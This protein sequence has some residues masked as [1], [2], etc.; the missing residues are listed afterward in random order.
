MRIQEPVSSGSL[1]ILSKSL[2]KDILLKIG[3]IVEGVVLEVYPQGGMTLKI[4]ESTLPVRSA[5]TFSKGEVLRLKVL[6]QRDKPGELVLKWVGTKEKDTGEEVTRLP[7]GLAEGGG[8]TKAND[9]ENT[10]KGMSRLVSSLSSPPSTSKDLEKLLET[11]LKVFY[12]INPKI[13]EKQR[14]NLLKILLNPLSEGLAGLT[15]KIQNILQEVPKGWIRGALSDSIQGM[16]QPM[17]MEGLNGAHLQEALENSGVLLETKIKAFAQETAADPETSARLRNKIINDSKYILLKL[18]A[19]I[20]EKMQTEVIKG[21]SE[22]AGERG[23]FGNPEEAV[24]SLKQRVEEINLLLHEVEAFQTLSKITDAL[25]FFLPLS[26]SSLKRGE[27]VFKKKGGPEKGLYS[28]GIRLYLDQVG[29]VSA[30]LLMLSTNNFYLDLRVEH[31]GLR[32]VMAAGLKALKERFQKQGLFL[33]Y[34]AAKEKKDTDL[35]PLDTALAGETLIN[36]RI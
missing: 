22:R 17:S 2:G 34:G 23:I 20:E 36:I 12:Q 24:I 9:P 16:G 14:I 6:G 7:K 27:L 25:V 5:L 28:C 15:V 13:S 30:F 4:R 33:T 19:I 8:I 10:V 31:D 26:W 3:E 18:K 35:D 32:A 1:L 21:V 29:E 11:V